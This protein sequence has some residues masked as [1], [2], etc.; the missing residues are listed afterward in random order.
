[1]SAVAMEVYALKQPVEYGK[2]VITEIKIDRQPKGKY[3]RLAQKPMAVKADMSG[4]NQEVTT[5]VTPG[6]SQVALMQAMTGQPME[7]LDELGVE[8]FDYLYGCADEMLG[9]FAQAQNLPKLAA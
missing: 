6:S 9:N 7:I 2:L 4:E 5:Y 8:D 3:W 1:M